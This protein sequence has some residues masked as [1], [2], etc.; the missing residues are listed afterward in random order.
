MHRERTAQSLEQTELA[1]WVQLVETPLVEQQF[2]DRAVQWYDLA[3][4]LRNLPEKIDLLFI[5]GPPG[6]MQ[7]LSRYP[8]LPVLGP[9]LSPQAL[10]VVDDGGREDETRMIELWRELDMPF[11]SETLSFLPRSPI[12]LEDGRRS[13]RRGESRASCGRRRSEARREQDAA[14]LIGKPGPAKSALCHAEADRIEIRGRDLCRDLMGRLTF[15]EFFFLLVTGREATEEQR[16]FLDLLLVAIAEHGL[17]P[18][19]QV[20]RMTYDAAPDSLQGAVAAGI[21]GCGPV[22]LGT[23]EACGDVLVE[24]RRRVEAGE[25]AD[26]VVRAHRRGDA[27][28]AAARCPASAIPIHHPV[29]PRAERILELADAARRRR[30][31]CRPRAPLRARRSR[32]PGASRCR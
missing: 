4:L 26:A 28:G 5:D 9:H 32:R 30:R 31:A 15:T 16:F 25:A 1:D 6:R 13:E 22:I 19:A 10:V 20:A 3:P 12:L 17:T 11:D 2:G 29:D 14:M 8:A 18:T 24:A 27:R 21:L 23:A 7:P